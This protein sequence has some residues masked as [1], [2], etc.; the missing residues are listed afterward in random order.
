MDYLFTLNMLSQIVI[1]I[2]LGE[3]IMISSVGYNNNFKEFVNRKVF[4]Q[5]VTSSKNALKRNYSEPPLYV[6]ELNILLL[7]LIN[8]YLLNDHIHLL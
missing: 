4:N 2:C 7:Y 6:D 3:A 5:C 1:K 8:L